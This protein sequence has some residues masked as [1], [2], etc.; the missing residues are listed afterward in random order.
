MIASMTSSVKPMRPINETGQDVARESEVI[1]HVKRYFNS[2]LGGN[3]EVIEWTAEK[4]AL[5]PIDC[6]L[7]RPD[8]MSMIGLE[9]KCRTCAIGQYNTYMIAEQ[10]ILKMVKMDIACALVVQWT[11]ALGFLMIDDYPLPGQYRETGGRKDR[12]QNG[13]IE[14]TTHIPIEHFKIIA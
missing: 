9:V 14:M 4:K 8:T 7:M 11:D 1:W 10:K 5:A 3:S 2:L 13:D 6:I 12:G